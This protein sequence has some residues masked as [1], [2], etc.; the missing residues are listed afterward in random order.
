[1]LSLNVRS[2]SRLRQAHEKGSKRTDI[3]FNKV[4]A[5]LAANR[6]GDAQQEVETA[7]KTFR[8]NPAWPKAYYRLARVYAQLGQKEESEQALSTFNEFKKQ[9]ANPDTEFTNAMQKELQ[10]ADQ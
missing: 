10:P 2:L 7:A 9:E 6:P 4:W 5:E 8:A 1:M 3:A